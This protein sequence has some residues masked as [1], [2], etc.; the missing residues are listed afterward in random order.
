MWNPHRWYLTTAHPPSSTGF[1]AE[2]T[3]RSALGGG[4]R[5]AG[6]ARREHEIAADGIAEFDER[7]LHYPLLVG[8]LKTARGELPILRGRESCGGQ[9]VPAIAI[10]ASRPRW[11][12]VRVALLS[13]SSDA[14]RSCHL[15]AVHDIRASLLYRAWW[16]GPC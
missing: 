14:A 7:E 13:Q 10:I 9:L 2:K 5:S 1:H 8:Q 12:S 3:R 11:R 15:H 4:R 6:A 16:Q